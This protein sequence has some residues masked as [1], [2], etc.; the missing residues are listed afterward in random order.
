[1]EALAVRPGAKWVLYGV[2][3]ADW[4]HQSRLACAWLPLASWPTRTSRSAWGPHRRWRTCPA[5]RMD[6]NVRN[7]N[8]LALA[9]N[10]EASSCGGWL[11]SRLP[12]ETPA[13]QQSS[14]NNLIGA[15]SACSLCIEYHLAICTRQTRQIVWSAGAQI[16]AMQ[17]VGDVQN[18]YMPCSIIKERNEGLRFQMGDLSCNDSYKEYGIP[19]SKS[20]TLGC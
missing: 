19:A 9:G 6:F 3:T 13:A 20:A 18:L 10:A 17:A 1:M 11:L 4:V 16:W 14:C 7:L 2:V 12:N 15:C 8:L 5:A